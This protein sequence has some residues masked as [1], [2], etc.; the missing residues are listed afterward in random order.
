MYEL[1]RRDSYLPVVYG[2]FW[3]VGSSGRVGKSEI[4]VIDVEETPAECGS[5]ADD[6][7]NDMAAPGAPGGMGDG[8]IVLSAWGG[9]MLVANVERR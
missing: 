5:D 8:F 3:S 6:P 7:E 2:Q 1:T 4:V 9:I